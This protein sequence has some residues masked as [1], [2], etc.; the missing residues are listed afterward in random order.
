MGILVHGSY[1]NVQGEKNDSN[2]VLIAVKMF[3]IYR[4]DQEF[5]KQRKMYI[6]NQIFLFSSVST[7][8]VQVAQW[9]LEGSI[10]LWNNP[11]VYGITFWSP[12][13]QSE[14]YE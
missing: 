6:V 2:L 10:C 13:K 1:S 12:L 14:L 9:P 3:S 8:D 4:V 7:I 5:H 11:Y